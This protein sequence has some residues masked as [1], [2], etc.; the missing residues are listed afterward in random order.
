[1]KP[2]WPTHPADLRRPAISL[3]FGRLCLVLIILCAATIGLT[4]FQDFG[5]TWDEAIH[6][7]YGDH[8]ARYY[9][10]GFQDK[11]VLT[12][13][14]ALY[15]GGFDLVGHWLRYAFRALP[16]IEMM[17]L[18]NFAVGLLGIAATAALGTMFRGPWCG[19]LAAAF[20]AL[21]PAYWGASFA[22]PKDIPFAA[23]YALATHALCKVVGEV[24]RT[25]LRTML[26]FGCCVGLNACVRV[27]GLII[28]AIL[29]LFV[30]IVAL[31]DLVERRPFRGVVFDLVHFLERAIPSFVLAWLIMLSAW[32]WAQQSPLM[33]PLEALLVMGNFTLFA[34]TRVFAGETFLTLNPPWDYIPRYLLFK[35]PEIVLVGVALFAGM[36]MTRWHPRSL[37]ATVEQ[38][39][40]IVLWMT[41]LIPPLFAIVNGST[42]YDGIRHFLFLFPG[43]C[44]AAALAFVWLAQQ[45]CRR[46]SLGIAAGGVIVLLAC[47]MHQ[48]VRTVAMHPVHNAGFNSFAGGT[49]GALGKYDVEYYGGSYKAAARALVRHLWFHEREAFVTKQFTFAS[50]SAD[51][52]LRM[53]LPKNF[54]PSSHPDFFFGYTRSN[55]AS[56]FPNKPEIVAV[57]R[58][59]ATLNSVKDLRD[60]HGQ[61]G[62]HHDVTK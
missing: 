57:V 33:R 36:S 41:L 45:T 51:D 46:G 47:C 8:I 3:W 58:D 23:T 61:Q 16:W 34:E 6:V 10:S 5:A 48:M 59:H 40:L 52:Y 28:F 17:H 18:F 49:R 9:T 15:G 14:D 11:A 56:R 38:R 60:K 39:R 31:H 37:I 53:Y 21:T 44:V 50:C 32:P 20:L 13:Q 29:G 54:R 7:D 12:H 27:A 4:T 26:V 24:P 25:N 30:V 2:I 22:N 43:L 35:L 19:A 55:C 62:G 1:M 42:L